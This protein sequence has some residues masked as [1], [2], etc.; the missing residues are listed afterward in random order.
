MSHLLTRRLLADPDAFS[1]K[2]S[3]ET[4]PHKVNSFF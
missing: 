3:A 2:C 1:V 4:D